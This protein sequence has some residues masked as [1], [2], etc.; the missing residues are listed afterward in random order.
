MR[1]TGTACASVSNLPLRF[2]QRY[3]PNLDEFRARLSAKTKLVSLASPQ[4]P[5]GVAIPLATLREFLALMGKICPDAY[6]L[7]DETFREA[8][9]GNDPVATSAITLGPKVI[10]IASLSKC[11]GAPGLRLGWVITQDPEL[12]EHLLIGKFNTV[13]SCSPLNEAVGLKV[14]QRRDLILGERRRHLA[15]TLQKTAQWVQE[16]SAFVEWVRPDAGALCCM[17]LAPSNF[18]D[19]ATK[20][21]FRGPDSAGREGRP[22]KLVW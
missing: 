3:L 4:N 15:H 6:L 18:D 7:V 10:S 16:N 12:R 19:S 14:L 20:R 17:R 9:Y 8:T 13:L 21:F 22:W 5:S 11:H 2:E 1:P